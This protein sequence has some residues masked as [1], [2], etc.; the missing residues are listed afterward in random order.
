[1]LLLITFIL[2]TAFGFSVHW[3]VFTVGFWLLLLSLKYGPRIVM[4]YNRRRDR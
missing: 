3:Y 2:L 4:E 1:M